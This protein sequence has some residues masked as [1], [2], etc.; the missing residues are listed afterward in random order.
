MICPNKET[1][2]GKNP[3]KR[4]SIP[5]EDYAVRLLARR[6]Y[7]VASLRKKMLEKQYG[8]TETEQVIYR[9]LQHGYL[10]DHLFAE[11]LAASLHHMGYGKKRIISKLR[12]KG[13]SGEII[14]ESLEK[15]LEKRAEQDVFSHREPDG[16]EKSEE[17][18][19]PEESAAL[20]ALKSKW[21]TLKN[22]PDVRK[23]K[24]KALRFLA[25]RGFEATVCYRTVNVFIARE[26]MEDDLS[27][28]QLK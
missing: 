27:F 21:R 10:N 20:K 12:E 18:D 26:N 22:E 9:F 8:T 15:I 25:G 4:K 2:N 17:F 23:K 3:E 11:S 24:E 14:Q 1:A 13:I 16:A 6:A 7:S 28:G 5:P 19:S